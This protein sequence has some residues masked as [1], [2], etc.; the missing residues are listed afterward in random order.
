MYG[1]ELAHIFHSGPKH[2]ID[3]GA[4]FI[5]KNVNVESKVKEGKVVKR[6]GRN[7]GS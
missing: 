5:V 1:D 2:E 3:D 7:E 6:K 4:K